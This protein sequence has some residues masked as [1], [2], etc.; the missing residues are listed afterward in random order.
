MAYFNGDTDG[1]SF[2][3]TFSTSY[4]FDAYP[5]HTSASEQGNDQNFDAFANGWSMGSQQNYLAGSLTGLG[6]GAGFG[7]C[8]YNPFE[9][10]GLTCA[11]PQSQSL[12]SRTTA[13]T[14]RRIRNTTGPSLASIPNPTPP[15]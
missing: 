10:R 4:E 2:Y 3:P 14:C 11:S 1:A 15:V 8:D 5:S 6:T 13:M 7:K 9:D 12:Q